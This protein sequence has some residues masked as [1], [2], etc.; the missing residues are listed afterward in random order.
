MGKTLQE[1]MDGFLVKLVGRLIDLEHLRIVSHLVAINRK[2]YNHT[3][4]VSLAKVGKRLDLTGVERTK[5]NVAALSAVI[6]K[7]LS[8]VS[9]GCYVPRMDVNRDFLLL[10][11]IC[12]Q[13]HTAVILYHPLPIAVL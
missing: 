4:T 6:Q 7:H 10:Q 1:S 12:S 13:Q 9:I 5:D 11:Y 8:D 3:D 2:R